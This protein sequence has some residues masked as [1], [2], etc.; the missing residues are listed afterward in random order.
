MAGT[1]GTRRVGPKMSVTTLDP[2][3]LTAVAD[4]CVELA[5]HIEQWGDETPWM[6]NVPIGAR[7]NE[8]RQAAALFARV[9]R[10]LAE[11]IERVN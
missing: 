1:F 10:D 11:E 7:L 9:L 6:R 8:V 5:E 4:Q 2:S 3:T